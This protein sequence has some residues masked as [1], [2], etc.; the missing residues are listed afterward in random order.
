MKIRTEYDGLVIRCATPAEA[1]K[2][3]AEDTA[4]HKDAHCLL[5]ATGDDLD[6]VITH[7]VGWE[8][9]MET[10]RDPSRLAGFAP[11]SDPNRILK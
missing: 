5:L 4:I 6:Y 10:D 8:E 2:I 1:E 11:A 9:D 7:A 3:R